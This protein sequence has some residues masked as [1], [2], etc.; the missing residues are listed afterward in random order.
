MI[1]FKGTLS[2]RQYMPV[3]LTKYGIK[4]CMAAD[5]KNR[6]II[7]YNVYLGSEESVPRIH[8]LATM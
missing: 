8:D 1:A 2:F 7:N 3:E 5:L 4:V 6:Y